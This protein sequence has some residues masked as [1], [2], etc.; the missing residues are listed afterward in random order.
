[1]ESS[2]AC[3]KDRGSDVESVVMGD[4]PWAVRFLGHWVVFSPPESLK[5][6]IPIKWQV[7]I[8]SKDERSWSLGNLSPLYIVGE[9][10][11]VCLLEIQKRN[12]LQSFHMAL[13][14][15]PAPALPLMPLL[16]SS[17]LCTLELARK[18]EAK[19]PTGGSSWEH[20]AKSELAAGNEC[21]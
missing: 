16:L 15:N 21:S 4:T 11:K 3:I 8:L 6:K 14:S 7:G 5:Q 9:S 10:L 13:L 1:M 17:P 19:T 18:E 20:C 12:S 2:T